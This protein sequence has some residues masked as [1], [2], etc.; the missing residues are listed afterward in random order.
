ME[1]LCL[2]KGFSALP[3]EQRETS[4]EIAA[5]VCR[6]VDRALRKGAQAWFMCPVNRDGRCLVYACRPMIC[7]LF[8]IPHELSKPGGKAVQ[9]SGCI[10]FSIVAGHKPY[11]R[12]DRTDFYYQMAQLES[13][14]RQATGLKGKIKM[15]VAEMILSFE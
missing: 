12:F 11:Y 13:E 9:H 10:E 15:T 7:R 5:D 2:E 3:G 14:L 1:L 4:K 8:G 6:K